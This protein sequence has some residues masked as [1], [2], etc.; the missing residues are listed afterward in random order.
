MLWKAPGYS[1]KYFLQV[2]CH[3]RKWKIAWGSDEHKAASRVLSSEH[4]VVWDEEPKNLRSV[5][6][7][8]FYAFYSLFLKIELIALE[9]FMMLFQSN[10]GIMKF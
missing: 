9:S 3:A 5:E 1:G 4:S 7:N 8:L 6:N 10:L 2:S